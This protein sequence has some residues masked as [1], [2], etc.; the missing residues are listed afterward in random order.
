MSKY[1]IRKSDIYYPDSSVPINKLNIQDANLLHALEEG[2]LTEAYSV[3]ISE[4]NQD[5]RFD[6]KYFKSLHARTFASLYE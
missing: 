1:L 6:E 3:F 5:T 2:L 4:L